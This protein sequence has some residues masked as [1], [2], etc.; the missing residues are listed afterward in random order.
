MNKKAIKWLYQ[1]LPEL[2]TRNILTQE[3]AGKIREY[4]GQIK[5]T[6]KLSVLLIICAVLGALFIGLGII[7]LLAHNW[8]QF[9]R[10]TRAIIS[11]APLVI[12]HMLALWV[13][14]K[15]PQS[16]AWKEATATFLSLM[17]GASIAL[18]SQ[19]YNI[20]GDAGTF[21]LTW[22]LLII[23]LVYLMQASIPA[24]IYL[25]GITVWSGSYWDNPIKAVL[26]WPMA[27]V[28]VPHFIW[29]LRQEIY[30]I[31]AT[32]L[33]L[34]M[35]ICVSFAAGFS[36]GRAWP[37]SWIV[38]FPSIYSIFYFIGCWKFNKI[39]AN[40]QRPFRLIGDN[41]LLI[42]AFLFTF[43]DIWQYRNAFYW[44]VFDIRALPDYIITLAII[45]MA[46]LLFYD[47]AKR[48]NMT[49]SLPGTLPLLTITAYFF[50]EV[51]AYFFWKVSVLL[52]FLIFNVY[53]FVLSVN[54]ITSGIRNNRLE[55][56]NNGML[57]LAV[58]II[59]RFFDS[60]IN[61]II[62]GLVFIIVGSGFLAT[63]VWLI[64]A[65]KEVRNE[66]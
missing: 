24:A 48:K 55:T 32:L 4:Y 11:F 34:V 21:T 30:T 16:S 5:T 9:S 27:A 23:P 19:T 12:G 35:I 43:R 64:R 42:L 46:V 66:K 51:T 39:T 60:D 58:L 62:K 63:N 59:A 33:S 37:S 18:I 29:A 50:R 15:R 47:N 20:P 61:F 44:E 40:W 54:R 8:E 52:P 17:V 22:M 53:L 36:L 6:S 38:I 25:I 26:F 57:M 49:I 7:L 3:A 45:A 13:L 1:E 10:F 31:R 28:V 56:I 2:I 41:G 65:M 14:W